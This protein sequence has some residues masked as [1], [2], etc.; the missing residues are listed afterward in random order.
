[1]AGKDVYGYAY[2]ADTQTDR[3]PA[4]QPARVR[5]TIVEWARRGRGA[6]RGAA[7]CVRQ[8]GCGG[9]LPP[10]L[11][12]HVLLLQ[13]W[14]GVWWRGVWWR[15]VRWRKLERKRQVSQSIKTLAFLTIKNSN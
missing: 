5:P 10:A 1:M 11:L 15:G 3:Q 7:L 2:A 8:T 4:S 13:H 12:A 6:L 9:K 14:V